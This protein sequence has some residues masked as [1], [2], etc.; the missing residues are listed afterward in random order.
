MV[1]DDD[2][3]FFVP[4]PG[5]SAEMLLEDADGPWTANI[6]RHEDV[7]V[8]PDVVARPNLVAPSM[9]GEDFLRQRH[10]RHEHSRNSS[11]DSNTYYS[12][13]GNAL[14]AGL[15]HPCLPG[16]AVRQQFAQVNGCE[17]LNT[18]LALCPLSLLWS[19]SLPC[20]RLL[21]Y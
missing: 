10:R 19:E 5:L 12:K 3:L 14:Q 2:H 20:N 7:H 15:G 21:P 1:G 18:S 11:F 16:S 17:M 4:D 8:D 13:P 6:V 9:A